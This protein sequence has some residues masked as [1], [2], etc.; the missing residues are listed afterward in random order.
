VQGRRRRRRSVVY[1]LLRSELVSFHVLRAHEL[2]RGDVVPAVVEEG[3]ERALQ[4]AM[5]HEL[6]QRER[7]REAGAEERHGSIAE[8]RELF[9][10]QKNRKRKTGE[11]D[12][13]RSTS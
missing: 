5:A 9:G 2:Q 10:E 13:R 12:S 7:R 8:K 11:E 1:P 4:G 3:G 6:L